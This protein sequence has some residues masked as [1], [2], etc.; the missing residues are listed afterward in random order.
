MEIEDAQYKTVVSEM[1]LELE[2]NLVRY[3]ERAHEFR[4]DK[5][6]LLELRLEQYQAFAEMVER[7]TRILRYHAGF[8]VEPKTHF[9]E[10]V[11]LPTMGGGV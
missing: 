11:L 8:S 6:A 4:D 5:E 3:N 7:H 9:G 10:A 2:G 1:V